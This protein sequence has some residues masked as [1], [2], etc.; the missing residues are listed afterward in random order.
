L[1]F[2][3]FFTSVT[4]VMLENK[5][6]RLIATIQAVGIILLIVALS[7][8]K[9]VVILS[10]PDLPE[11]ATITINTASQ[12]YKK[13]WALFA[14]TVI[15]NVKPGNVDFVKA[16]LE[17]LLEPSLYQDIMVGVETQGQEIKNQGLTVTF[18]PTGVIYDP[19]KDQVYV[20]GESAT[21]G[22][23]GDPVREKKTYEIQI[24]VRNYQ[25]A[26]THLATYAGGPKL[27]Q[28]KEE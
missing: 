6:L 26:I 28:K 14:A 22:A 11:T 23:Y 18:N 2:Q 25:P 8:K 4:G 1:N 17:K 7:N 3:D 21:Q 16:T 12:E 27:K 20:T 13:S 24:R 10:P 19:E 9:P 15:G 5:G